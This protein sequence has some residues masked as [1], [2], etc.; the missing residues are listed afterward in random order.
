MFIRPKGTN[1]QIKMSKGYEVEK[2]LNKKIY[3]NKIFYYLK[4]KNYPESESTWEPYSN[5]A[6]IQNLIDD[7]ES[8]VNKKPSG[9]VNLKKKQA[10]EKLNN[11]EEKELL[12]QSKFILNF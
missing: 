7:Y 5:L 12:K 9:I 11:Q 8:S 3:K 10:K 6:N 1:F 2:V 4:W